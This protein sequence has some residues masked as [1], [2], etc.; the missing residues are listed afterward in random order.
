MEQIRPGNIQ[1]LID[2]LPKYTRRDLGGYILKLESY[3]EELHDVVPKKDIINKCV[4]F[5]RFLGLNDVTLGHY[6]FEGLMFVYENRDKLKKMNLG[7][8][9][10][11]CDAYDLYVLINGKPKD[12]KDLT[13]LFKQ[14]KETSINEIS[15]NKNLKLWEY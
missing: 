15:I 9:M 7:E 14:Q 5:C 4:L 12:I 11:L 10:C 13:K 8:L 2:G 1:K 6:S 3:I